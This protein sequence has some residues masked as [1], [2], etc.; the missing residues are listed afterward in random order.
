MITI[1]TMMT[2]STIMT[3][4]TMM[5]ISTMLSIVFGRK[6]EVLHKEVGGCLISYNLQ[7]ACVRMLDV[8]WPDAHCRVDRSDR[9]TSLSQSLT[10][11]RRELLGQLEI[12][13]MNTFKNTIVETQESFSLCSVSM[14]KQSMLWLL[15]LLPQLTAWTV[16][17]M[18][19]YIP[20]CLER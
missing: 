17:Y 10:H 9:K 5:T 8:I 20:S 6:L 1:S 13:A 14:S 15:R 16:A 12:S 11:S 19:K 2:I 7:L 3:I 4:A 18:P